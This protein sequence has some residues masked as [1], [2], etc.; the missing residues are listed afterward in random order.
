[1]KLVHVQVFIAVVA[2][3]TGTFLPGST[4][5]SAQGTP[6]S[7]SPN[8]SQQQK[9]TNT[10]N[11]KASDYLVQV[12]KHVMWKSQVEKMHPELKKQ[13]VQI[14]PA[15]HNDFPVTVGKR[16]VMASTLRR[17]PNDTKSRA[18]TH[19]KMCRDYLVHIG[20]QPVWAS[21]ANCPMGKHQGGSKPLCCVV[22]MSDDAKLP[23]CCQDA[24]K[25]K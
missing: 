24:Q 22:P 11:A 14:S 23:R 21:A 12:G 7:G 3:V 10:P 4:P 2:A 16:T 5:V 20:K 1:M 25:Q 19:D 15:R 13:S 17:D 6:G 9:Q 8:G 18:T